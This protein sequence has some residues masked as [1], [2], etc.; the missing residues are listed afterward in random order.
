MFLDSIERRRVLLLDILKRSIDERRTFVGPQRDLPA[1][2]YVRLFPAMN[3][4]PMLAQD[5]AQFAA[6]HHEVNMF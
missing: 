3:Q 5:L 6:V 2:Q 1:C 4:I